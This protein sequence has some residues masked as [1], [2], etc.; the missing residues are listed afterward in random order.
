MLLGIFKI[1]SHADKA[2]PSPHTICRAAEKILREKIKIIGW[3]IFSCAAGATTKAHENCS[4]CLGGSEGSGGLAGLGCLGSLKIHTLNILNL[5][6]FPNLLNSTQT[7]SCHFVIAPKAQCTQSSR[8]QTLWSFEADGV[9]RSV[10]RLHTILPPYIIFMF[11]K[12]EAR[13]TGKFITYFCL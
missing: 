6:N 9:M 2:F 13:T 1:L 7:F 12:I 5:P 8:S 3:L 11:G 4:V 10:E